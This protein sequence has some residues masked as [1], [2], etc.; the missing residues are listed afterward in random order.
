VV[1]RTFLRSVLYLASLGLA[2]H[3]ILPQ[4]PG[5]QRSLVLIAGS[6]RL[7]L[8]AALLAFLASQV[9]YAELLGRS[10]GAAVGAGPSSSRR[11]L[12]LG[13]GFMLRIALAEHGAAR[14]LPGGGSS[15]AAVTYTG[16]RSRGFK[17]TRIG[18]AVATIT[19]LVYGTLGIIFLASLLYLTLDN[20]L[21]RTTTTAA[22]IVFVLTIFLAFLAYLAYLWPLAARRFLTG[23]FY[24]LGRIFR[25]NWSRKR[26]EMR[27]ARIVVNL[28]MEM[29]ALREQLIGHP[30]A[31]LRLGALALGYWGFDALCLLIIFRAFGVSANPVDLLVAYGVATTFGSLPLTPGGLGVF[32]ATM[33]GTLA[34][35][36]VGYEAAIPVLGYRL[37]NFWLPIPLAMILYPTLH[38]GASKYARKEETKPAAKPVASRKKRF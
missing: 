29:R 22:L 27:A 34:L 11:L 9:C 2:L 37:F 8:L 7:L 10:A 6:S 30:L 14:V 1:R 4:L 20:A 26:T 25:R 16:L 33:L 15:A 19:V 38:I 13:R 18:L 17:P 24:V 35:L 32:E 3:L 5:I 28:K 36:G 23:L 21:G 31:A 12:G